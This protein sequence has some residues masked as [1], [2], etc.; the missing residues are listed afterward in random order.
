MNQYTEGGWNAENLYKIFIE[1]FGGQY[2][3]VDELFYLIIYSAFEYNPFG[4]HLGCL[5]LHVANTLLVF[6]CIKYLLE[7]N[8]QFETAHK[9]WIAFLSALIFAVHPM[10]VES[11]AWISASKVLVYA[12]FYLLATHTFLSYLKHGKITYYFL[13]LFLFACSF[14][15]KEQ[16]ICF[17]LWIM[18]IY[19]LAGYSFK[20]RKVWFRVTPFLLL[21]LGFGVITFYANGGL[22]LLQELNYPFWQKIVYACYSFTEY[23]LKTAF[24]FNLYYLY[25][26]PSAA[27]DPLPQWLLLYPMLTGILLFALWK[28]VKA[29]KVLLF[30]LLFFG[31][32]LIFALHIISLPRSAV[33]ADRYV[34]LS[35]VGFGLLVGY[36]LIVLFKKLRNLGKVGLIMFFSA[37]LLYLGIYSNIRC[38]VWQNSDTLKNEILK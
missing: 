23:L 27:G 28:P 9:Q 18:L 2:S 25:P 20:D 5:I 32:H 11:V 38:R 17:P 26:F 34:Y 7:I 21:S 19:W 36:Y 6:V 31:I 14:G 10:N 22:S 3:P 24:P 35:S 12:F 4:F 15:G 1:F 37:Y 33:V 29:N 8:K 30:C 13:T 16:A